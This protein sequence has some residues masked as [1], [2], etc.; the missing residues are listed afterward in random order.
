[1]LTTEQL[2]QYRRDGYVVLPELFDRAHMAEAMVEVER[3]FY[4]EPFA[5]YLERFQ[6]GSARIRSG[7]HTESNHGRTAFPTGLDVL[8]RIIEH[9]DYLDAFEQCLGTDALHYCSSHLFMRSGPTDSR[10]SEHPWQGYHIDHNQ[11]SFLPPHPRLDDNC[12]VNSV[13]Y[14]HDV[15]EACAPTHVIP[16][17]HRVL[18]DVFERLIVDGVF[19]NKGLIEDIRKVPEFAEPVKMTA[20]AG[21]VVIFSSYLIHAPVPFADRRRQRVF[22][23]LSVARRDTAAWTKFSNPYWFGERDYSV[24]FWTRTSPR[25]RS[26]FGWPPPGHPFYTDDTLRLLGVWYPEMDLA[27]YRDALG[28]GAA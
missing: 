4:G 8:D 14:L 6:P 24:P 10:H 13:V 22:W 1:M 18:F 21:S 23:T 27:P 26:L 17:S 7:L 3:I 15:D 20:P 2:E 11:N 12:Y 5:D 16:G 9:D 25:V 19:T 28:V